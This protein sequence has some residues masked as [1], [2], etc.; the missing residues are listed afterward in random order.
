MQRG[1]AWAQ[2]EVGMSS[3]PYK[4]CTSAALLCISIVQ[5]RPD[6]LMEKLHQSHAVSSIQG[7][8]LSHAAAEAYFGE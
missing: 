7:V 8:T 5:L 2:A 6:V 3:M 1:T 4:T